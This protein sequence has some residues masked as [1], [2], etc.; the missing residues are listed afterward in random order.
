[1]TAKTIFIAIRCFAALYVVSVLI[2]SLAG[3]GL[4][5]LPSKWQ[6]I[7]GMIACFFCGVGMGAIYPRLQ[8]LHRKHVLMALRD[9]LQEEAVRL[10]NWLWKRLDRAIEKP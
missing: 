10:P 9:H 2:S 3:I 5:A 7:A 8:S 6:A 4:D 1:M